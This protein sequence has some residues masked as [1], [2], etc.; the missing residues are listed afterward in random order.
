MKQNASPR[1]QSDPRRRWR[2][3][4]KQTPRQENQDSQHMLNQPRGSFPGKKSREYHE[5]I[6]KK[7]NIDQRDFQKRRQP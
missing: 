7:N 5:K 4:Q 6:E 3:G 1:G 2:P